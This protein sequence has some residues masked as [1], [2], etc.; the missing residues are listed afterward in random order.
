M[1]TNLIQSFYITVG[2]LNIPS[3]RNRLK[4]AEMITKIILKRLSILHANP[5]LL[6]L[7]HT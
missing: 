2:Y 4:S 6:V 5:Y 3:V 1:C 7:F